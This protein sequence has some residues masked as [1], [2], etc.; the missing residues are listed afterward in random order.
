METPLFGEISDY[1]R[2]KTLQLRNVKPQLGRQ[3][4]K[5]SKSKYGDIRLEKL[6]NDDGF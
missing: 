3:N 1:L 5:K 4:I 2:L 6:E